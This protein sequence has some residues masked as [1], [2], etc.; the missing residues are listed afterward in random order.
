V[1]E[2]ERGR[3]GQVG[4][5]QQGDGEEQHRVECVSLAVGGAVQRSTQSAS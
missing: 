2:Q 4:Q 3:A 1:L 5:C